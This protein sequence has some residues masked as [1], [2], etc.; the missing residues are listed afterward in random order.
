[1]SA[2][3]LD[4]TKERTAWRNAFSSGVKLRSM[5]TLLASRLPRQ[6]CCRLPFHGLLPFGTDPE[7]ASG[8][9]GLHGG[10]GLPEGGGILRG[11]GG[12]PA[13]GQPLGPDEDHRGPQGE[14]AGAEA[15]SEEHTSELQS[16]FDLVCRLLLE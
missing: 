10:G 4:C 7:A 11:G 3:N 14:G 16:R 8:A 6:R 1:M 13:Q 5:R 9:R 2:G 15:R 12:E